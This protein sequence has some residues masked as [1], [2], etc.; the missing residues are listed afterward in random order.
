[1]RVK[2]NIRRRRRRRSKKEENKIKI[3]TI[4]I[5]FTITFNICLTAKLYNKFMYNYIHFI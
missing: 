5:L 4:C 3:S 1:M 2:G